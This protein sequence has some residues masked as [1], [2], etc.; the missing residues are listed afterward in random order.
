MPAL[1]SP[2]SPHTFTSVTAGKSRL[3]WRDEFEGPQG[4]PPDPSKWRQER[5]GEGW[6][7]HE[8]QYYTDQ[9]ENAVLDGNGCLAITAR[10]IT[11]ADPANRMCWYGPGRFTSARLNTR[12]IFSFTYGVVEAR[13]KLPFGQGIWPAFWMLGANFGEVGWP[14]CGE[15]DIMENIGREPGT[16]HGTAHGPGYSGGNGLGGVHALPEG[17]AMKDAFHIFAVEWQ[18]GTIRWYLDNQ[19]YCEVMQAQ[20]PKGTPWPFDRPFFLLLN[21]AVGGDWPGS[22]DDTTVFPQVMLVDF[23]RVYQTTQHLE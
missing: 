10:T 11:D 13:I 19:L 5:G 18:P 20:L 16:V 7:N 3:V 2:T 15:I 4:A 17:Q 22:P 21:M 12:G 23:V 14:E 8:L 6:G 1:P 9:A